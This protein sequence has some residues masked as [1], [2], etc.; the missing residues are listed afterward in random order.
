MKSGEIKKKAFSI[1][2]LSDI[3]YAIQLISL[4]KMKKAQRMLWDTQPFIKEVLKILAEL[5]RHEKVK[6]SIYFKKE[7]KKTLAVVI[8]SDRGFCGSFNRNI[9]NFAYQ[10]IE[11]IGEMDVFAVGK[12]AILFFQRKKMKIVEKVTGIGDFGEI[13]ETKPIADKLIE[14]FLKGKYQKIYLFYTKFFST[15]FQKPTTFQLL[16]LDFEAVT[17]LLKEYQKEKEKG[18]F[19][20][21]EPSPEEIFDQLVPHLIRYLVHYAILEANAS[22]HSARFLA[23]KRAVDNTKELIYNLTLIYNKL[24]QAEI[25]NE[26]SEIS[27]AKEALQ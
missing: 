8:S 27:L 16:P 21:L 9:L 1:K 10:E 22:E 25:T 23:M 14:F 7:A 19:V 12:K 17:T 20:L 18:Y 26:V 3:L 2:N 24:R 15:F 13:H 6:E 4:I 5:I 11:K